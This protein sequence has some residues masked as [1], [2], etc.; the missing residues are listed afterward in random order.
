MRV[1][2]SK[3]GEDGRLRSPEVETTQKCLGCRETNVVGVTGLRRGL[4]IN[5]CGISRLSPCRNWR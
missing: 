2:T 3:E 1:S 4:I 5:R